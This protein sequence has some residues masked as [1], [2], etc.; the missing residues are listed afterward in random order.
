M[1]PRKNM[2]GL[3]RQ[4]VKESFSY[5]AESRNYIYIMIGFFVLS[6]IAGFYFVGR[7]GFLD[8]VLKE[9]LDK[10]EGLNGINLILFIFTNNISVAFGSIFLGVI[11]GVFPLINSISNGVV[12]GYVLARVFAVSGFSEFWRIL[13]HGV[14]ELPAI[15]ISLG[16]G[17]RLGM[18]VFS[19]SIVKDFRHNFAGSVKVFFFVVMPLLVLAAIIEGLLIILLK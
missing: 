1:K 7:L 19:K 13:P 3:C 14:F 6:T 8:A 12:L 4:Y 11:L 9:L 2:L 5:I 15:F 16:L 10:T 18:S 17:L